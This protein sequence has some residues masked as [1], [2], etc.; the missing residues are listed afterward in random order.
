MNKIVK[1]G[2]WNKWLVT[3]QVIKQVQINSLISDDIY[4]HL[5]I[6]LIN[7]VPEKKCN[8]FKQ[9]FSNFISGNYLFFS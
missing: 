4:I 8:F 6:L 1:K 3:H 9:Y 2:T 5:F 7:I